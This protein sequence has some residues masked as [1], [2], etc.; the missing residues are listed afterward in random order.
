MAKKIE[1][2]KKT[3]LHKAVGKH[4]KKVKKPSSFKT[5]NKTG[6]SPTPFGKRPSFVA[7]DQTMGDAILGGGGDNLGTRGVF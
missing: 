5:L 2:K 7:K 1:E 4:I 6:A 3:A